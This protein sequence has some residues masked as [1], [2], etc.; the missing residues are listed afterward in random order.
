[1]LDELSHYRIYAL[2]HYLICEIFLTF[3]FIS[4]ILSGQ[5]RK[6]IERRLNMLLM[7]TFTWI[8]I[9]VA[10]LILAAFIGMK[11]KDKYY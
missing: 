5:R 1:M 8:I 11:I 9:G 4:A 7:G 3:D 2:T 6:A 10:V